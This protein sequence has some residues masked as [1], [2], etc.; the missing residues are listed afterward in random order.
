MLTNRAATA[1]ALLT[2]PPKTGLATLSLIAFA[3]FIALMPW[4]VSAQ[5][6][7]HHVFIGSVLVGGHA[8]QDGSI[9]T[10]WIGGRRVGVADVLRESRYKMVIPPQANVSFAGKEV[11]F[12]LDGEQ[13]H[14]AGTWKAGGITELDLTFAR[15]ESF[16]PSAVSAQQRPS[17]VFS[18]SV[19]V[20]DG[21]GRNGSIVTAWISGR[22]VG[23]VE[24]RQGRFRMVIPRH[25]DTAFTGKEVSFWL[26][27]RR[28][29][30]T[31]IWRGGGTTDLELTITRAEYLH[32][33]VGQ[34][35]TSPSVSDGNSSPATDLSFVGVEPAV[36]ETLGID[37]G[38]LRGAMLRLGG[39]DRRDG[40]RSNGSEIKATLNQI[41]CRL[42]GE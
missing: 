27:A 18:G 4:R 32:G 24:V 39:V 16:M 42:V 30:G 19:V 26:D 6:E 9:L 7:S 14:W 36:C 37:G 41:G 11:S 3:V 23:V 21:A 34:S 15:S 8:A 22:R 40:V 20:G 13:F 2:S 12:L 33:Q 10:A 5:Q 29:H 1:K 25:E 31:G 17:H 38:V 28:L 35:P